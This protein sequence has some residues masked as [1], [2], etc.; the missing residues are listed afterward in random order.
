MQESALPIQRWVRG[1]VYNIELFQ[2][3]GGS[4]NER[5]TL[6]LNKWINNEQW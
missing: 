4:D 2:E 5:I 3:G 1:K 6:T